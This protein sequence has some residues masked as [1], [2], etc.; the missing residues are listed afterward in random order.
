[1]KKKKL[2]RSV[3]LFIR[4]EK[5]KIRKE[6]LSKKEER[7]AFQKIYERFLRTNKE[8]KDK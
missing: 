5:A 3:R 4:G 7:E 1:M 8:K 2:P 6:S